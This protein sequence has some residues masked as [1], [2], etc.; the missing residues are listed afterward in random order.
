MRPFAY[1]PTKELINT[2]LVS[3]FSTTPLLLNNSEFL[4][5]LGS[6]LIGNDALSFYL[7]NTI[8][9][10]FSAGETIDSLKLKLES[11]S[12]ISQGSI[13]DYC[14]EGEKSEQFMNRTVEEIEKS[15]VMAS[16]FIYPSI[17]IKLTSLIPEETLIK[18]NSIQSGLLKNYDDL[19]DSSIFND[20]TK[21]NLGKLGFDPKE[22]LELQNG[23]KRVRKICL[24]CK[25]NKVNAMI[26]AEQ[27]YFQLAIDA[28]AASLQKEF[29]KADGIVLNTIQSYLTNSTEKI[30]SYVKW[31]KQNQ[32]KTGIKLVRGAYMVEENRLARN[33]NY[34][35]PVFPSKKDTDNCYDHNLELLIN[36][37]E[38][39][40]SLCVATH[41]ENTVRLA[42]NLMIQKKSHRTFSGISFAQLLGMKS[43]IGSELINEHYVVRKYIPFGPFSKLI[44]YLLR[45]SYEQRDM[46]GDIKFELEEMFKELK[47]RENL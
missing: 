43:I 33:F 2:Y 44:P 1:L 37:H 5:N 29:N 18:A 10:I 23:L 14:V 19:W 34:I 28:I 6:S 45:R 12:K 15:I 9:R 40:S 47:L 22:I 36:S 41:N 46:L 4:A 7:G 30:A 24:V 32:L 11:L 42:K 8:G 25:E 13:M 17:A 31:S 39:Y 27:S 21:E 16:K 20:P 38:D 35:S 26:D 3:K